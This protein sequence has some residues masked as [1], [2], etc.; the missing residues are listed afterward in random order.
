MSCCTSGCHLQKKGVE[1]AS[2]DQNDDFEA[3]SILSLPAARSFRRSESFA[4]AASDSC[5]HVKSYL[6]F[7]YLAK[8]DLTFFTNLNTEYFLRIEKAGPCVSVSK[9]ST[10]AES[11]M[12]VSVAASSFF[13]ALA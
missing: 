13:A 1:P 2:Q 3:L 4:R 12:V 11:H 10:Q 7:R 5:V 8:L 9:S 6:D